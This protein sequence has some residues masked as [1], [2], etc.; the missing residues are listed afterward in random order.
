MTVALDPTAGLEIATG[1]VERA[2]A[3]GAEE[4]K[5]LHTYTDLFEV[6]FD[7]HD[8][9]LVRSAVRD[10]VEIT[11]YEG[12]RKGAAKLTGR[13]HDAIDEAIAGALVSA[14]A[15]VADPANVLPTEHQPAGSGDGPVEPDADAMVSTVVRHLEQMRD[16]YPL[17]RTDSGVYELLSGWSSYADSNG[18]QQHVR[19]TAYVVVVTVAAKDGDQTTSLNY[20]QVMRSDPVEDITSLDPVKQL[21]DEAMASLRT[22]SLPDTFVGPVV[23]APM[24]LAQ[25]I[26]VLAGALGGFSLFRKTSPYLD[27]LGQS[28]A[29]PGFNLLHRPSELVAADPIDADG[30]ANTDLD[31]IRDGV[32]QSYLIDWANS[33]RLERP[34]TAGSADLVVEPGD[35]A[36][37]EII[38]G[39]DRGILMGRYSGG[40]P[41]NNLDFSGVAKNSFLI[42]K[43]KVTEPLSETM[44][45]GNFA[46]ALRSVVGI[47][48]EVVDYG[49]TRL[50]WVAVDGITVSGK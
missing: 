20:T 4:A 34:R 12:R 9:K 30:F 35:R 46:A 45:A 13:S 40:M 5:V 31:V 1:A 22:G 42:E 8:V 38:S 37:D 43:G 41:G 25:L 2:K 28:I 47:S 6:N 21:F 48:R 50:P 49:S 3:A 32:L 33:I 15:G 27:S 39:I 29:S 14:R 23:L 36:L 10:D 7:T 11:V 19:R 44:V 17:I 26:Q 24:A 18:R 16:V